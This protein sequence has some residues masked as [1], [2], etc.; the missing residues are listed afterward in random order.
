M[1]NI[2]KPH[3]ISLYV[4]FRSENSAMRMSELNFFGRLEAVVNLFEGLVQRTLTT[5]RIHKATMG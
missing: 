3:A 2:P 4:L 1:Q 5:F